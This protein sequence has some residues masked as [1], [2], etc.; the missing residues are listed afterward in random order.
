YASKPAVDLLLG[1]AAQESLLGT[2]VR[3]VGGGPAL[4]I[5]QM[6]PATHDDI[7][8]NFIEYQPG[9]QASLDEALDGAMAYRGG[10]SAE[11]LVYDL[12]YATI[13]ARL[14]YYRRPEPLPDDLVGLAQYWKT[15]YNTELGAGT[16]S[17]YVH[18]ARTLLA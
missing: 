13:M 1:T 7:W 17:E 18:N 8:Q 10:P 3:Q 5:Y 15:H 9:V 4:G 16:V 11:R 12:R 6:E 14:H 2:Y